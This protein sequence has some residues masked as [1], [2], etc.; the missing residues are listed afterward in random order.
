MNPV[1]IIPAYRPDKKTLSNIVEQIA[2][3]DVAKIII[4][5]D[6][7]GPEF[8]SVFEQVETIPKTLVLYHEANQGKG[9]ALRTG[10]RHVKD[11][12]ISCTSVITV[13]ADGQHLPEDVDKIIG[14]IKKHPGS[15][16]LGVRKFKGNVPLRSLLG[17][18]A[19]YLMFRGLVGQTISD[20]QTGLRG[21]PCSLL[22]ELLALR[23]DRYAYEL[24][25]LLTLV[26]KKV[27]VKE[28]TITTVYE[29]NNSVSSFNPVS[30]SFMIYKTLFLWWFTFRFKQLLKYSLSGMFSTIA[31]FGAYILLINLSCGFVTASI[32]ARILSV[33]IHFSANKYFTFSYKDAPNLLEIA[34]YLVVVGFNLSS[35]I[36]LIYVFIQYLSAGEVVAKVMAQLLLFFATYAL[37]N[38]FVFLRQKRN[39]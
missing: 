4:V 16:V 7:S 13:D 37:L 27:P 35:S 25:M 6:G 34:K 33:M 12:R 10:F 31:D 19:T 28:V 3:F 15:L 1:V 5:D 26:Q 29:D 9:A 18:K 30:D 24:E 21:I 11:Y 23:S 8:K 17:N 36:F 22:E 14:S 20:T 2:G 32:L 39:R 38:G